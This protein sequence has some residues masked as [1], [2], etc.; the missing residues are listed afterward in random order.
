MRVSV[1]AVWLLS[2]QVVQ[3]CKLDLGVVERL[4]PNKWYKLVQCS[5]VL[6]MIVV[7]ML[8]S[9]LQFNPDINP[10]LRGDCFTSAPI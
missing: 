2:F 7:S 4:C 10:G 8:I 9:L 5:A 1:V 3:G 6:V